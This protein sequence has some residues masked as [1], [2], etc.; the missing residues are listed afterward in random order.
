MKICQGNRHRRSSIQDA[1]TWVG[2]KARFCHPCFLC[3]LQF[4]NAI[5]RFQ[6]TRIVQDQGNCCGKAHKRACVLK[7]RPLG[8]TATFAAASFSLTAAQA[9]GVALQDVYV[10]LCMQLIS[11]ATKPWK[12]K[13]IMFPLLEL[14]KKRQLC[15]F[16]FVRAARPLRFPAGTLKVYLVVSSVQFSCV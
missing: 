2:S 6:Q 1:A 7:L 12:F 4:K 13:C 10:I 9:D 8:A 5:C 15:T 3:C 16:F 11:R 14:K